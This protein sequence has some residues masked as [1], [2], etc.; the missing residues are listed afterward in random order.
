MHYKVPGTT[1]QV[2][3]DTFA[4]DLGRVDGD[5]E[6]R[7]VEAGPRGRV[8]LPAVPRTAEDKS[9]R[10]GVAARPARDPLLHRPEAERTAVVRTAVAHAAK[11]PTRRH[12]A[13][14]TSFHPVNDVTVPLQIGERAD[15]VP[16]HAGTSPRRSP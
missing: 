14:L 6:R 9:R 5:A 2:N 1:S 16:A 13:D 12:N 7:I 11:L 3:E 10:N 8:E 15:V 4:V